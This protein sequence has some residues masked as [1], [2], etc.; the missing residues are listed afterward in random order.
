MKIT[1]QKYCF[2]SVRST[3]KLTIT[4]KAV[5]FIKSKK[6]KGREKKNKKELGIVL[7][8]SFTP[9][10]CC[11]WFLFDIHRRLIKATDFS[12]SRPFGISVN[13]WL[14]ITY[15]FLKFNVNQFLPQ[16]I[17]GWSFINLNRKFSYTMTIW[18]WV[19]IIFSH[20]MV[21]WTKR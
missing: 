15:Y 9:C 3:N 11:F 10:K 18:E 17:C 2:F 20:D 1:W 16:C 21:S 7:C 19:I 14:D 8:F 5:I 13:L 4:P 6:K 12:S